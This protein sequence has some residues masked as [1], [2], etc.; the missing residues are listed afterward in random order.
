M[1]A[2]KVAKR[3]MRKQMA[4]GF[5]SLRKDMLAKLVPWDFGR[6]FGRYDGKKERGML[7]VLQC[8][9][10]IPPMRYAQAL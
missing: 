10:T 9:S 7:D 6:Y 4:P 1:I 3:M 5:R 2:I 8:F